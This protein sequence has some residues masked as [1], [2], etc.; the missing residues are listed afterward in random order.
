MRIRTFFKGKTGK[1]GPTGAFGEKGRQGYDGPS[2][3]PGL[4]GRKGMAGECGYK[5]QRGDPGNPGTN[6]NHYFL[7]KITLW[8]ASRNYGIIKKYN[9][10]YFYLR[11][12]KFLLISPSNS[13]YWLN[14]G[15]I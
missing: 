2:G 8:G 6:V 7:V 13:F 4:D 11:F 1:H 5:G 10:V 3:T 12:Q 14:M 9:S 15:Q